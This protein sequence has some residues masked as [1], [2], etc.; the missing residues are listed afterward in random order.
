MKSEV[1]KAECQRDWAQT[2]L[3]TMPNSSGPF[4]PGFHRVLFGR[5][6]RILARAWTEQRERWQAASLG[7]LQE[8]FGRALPERLAGYRTARGAGSRRR[9]FDVPTTFWA[10]LHQ[11]R[12]PNTSQ[13][14]ATARV[15]AHLRVRT[16]RTCSEQATAFCKARRRLPMTL[17]EEVL[18]HSAAHSRTLLG[19]EANWRGHRVW[20]V[21]GTGLL[22]ADTPAN[23][24]RWPQSKSQQPGCGFPLTRLLGVFDLG[25]GALHGLVQ[26]D[27]RAHDQR[28]FGCLLKAFAKDDVVVGDRAFCAWSNFAQLN[29]RGACALFRQHQRRRA[30]FR[31]G[32]RLGPD[33]HLVEWPKPRRPPEADAEAW[34]ALPE[35]LT[36]R[37]VRVKISAPGV[38]T[39]SLVLVTTLLDPKR[40]PHEELA[41]LYAR[42]WQIELC[43][44]DLKTT[45]GLETLRAKSPASVQRELFLRLIAYNLLRS[46]MARAALT[47]HLPVMRLSFRGSL[48]R[49]RQ[50]LS[51]L[52]LPQSGASRR[53]LH[54]LLLEAIARDALPDRPGRREPRAVKRRAKSY[55]L[56]NRP[57]HLMREIG[58]RNRHRACA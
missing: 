50:Y 13:R 47:H 3:C 41:A 24:E 40:Y 35:Q 9:I 15:Q 6:P 32:R 54:A 31:C 17:L 23:Q 56:L 14:E 12:C 30:D 39:R 45:L 52:G 49:A 26:S 57:R 34:A 53:R 44:D 4:F 27:R 33:D 19:D 37:E 7:E 43:F 11:A 55:Q 16:G 48:D 46:L 28:L 22:L 42:R 18:G 10:A 25:T 5:P 20:L 1:R 21:D 29:A 38:R 2:D 51:T 58:H 36:L 8:V